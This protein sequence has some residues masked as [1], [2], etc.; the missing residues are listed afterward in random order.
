M[1]HNIGIWLGLTGASIGPADAHWLGLL[2]HCIDARQFDTIAA[3]LGDAQPIDALLDGQLPNGQ[4]GAPEPPPLRNL[5][6]V[7]ERCFGADSIS[8][9]LRNLAAE[10][11]HKAWCEAARAM[12]ADR[13]PLALATTLELIRRAR[14]LDLRHVLVLEYRLARTLSVGP[15]F[16][17]GVRTRVIEKRGNPT[18]S[19]PAT[20]DVGR[21]D[22]ERL[23]QVR[24]TGELILPTRQEMQAA[25]I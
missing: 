19:P 17:E 9:I 13:S 15:D 20:S 3:A 25:R 1:P 18:W 2:T 21:A 10:R 5:A 8:G 23:F 22:I 7:I 14:H 16:L 12:L 4:A 11:E 6:A 24:S